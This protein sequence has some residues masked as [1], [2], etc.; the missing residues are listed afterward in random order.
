[1]KYVIMPLAIIANMTAFNVLGSAAHI[2]RISWW[3]VF[4]VAV[5]L[6]LMCVWSYLAG[7]DEQ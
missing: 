6:L 7:R 1:M 3:A 4:L 2:H 5:D